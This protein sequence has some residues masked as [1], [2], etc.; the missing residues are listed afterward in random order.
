MIGITNGKI[1][2]VVISIARNKGAIYVFVVALKKE[3]RPKNEKKVESRPKKVAAIAP[4]IAPIEKIGVTSPPLNPSARKER[5][6]KSLRKGRLG[7][8]FDC[9][10]KL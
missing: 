8:I 10:K 2:G 4:S 5:V 7:E 6:K 1:N 9:S 3:A